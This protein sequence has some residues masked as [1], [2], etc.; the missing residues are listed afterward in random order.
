M[1]AREWASDGFFSPGTGRAPGLGP[2]PWVPSLAKCPWKSHLTSLR[3]I[4]FFLK[5]VAVKIV[6]EL[7]G[8]EGRACYG[9]GPEHP[10]HIKGTA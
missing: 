6:R 1:R 5:P 3:I 10:N 8:H 2:E 9:W 4:F 7:L